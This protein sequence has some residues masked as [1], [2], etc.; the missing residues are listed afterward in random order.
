VP[1]ASAWVGSGATRAGG[2]WPVLL[3][4]GELAGAGTS[5]AGGGL[6][7]GVH[8]VQV[9]AGLLIAAVGAVVLTGRDGRSGLPG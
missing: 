3:V 7:A 8:L 4:I 5:R 9:I 2:W 1:L 6:V